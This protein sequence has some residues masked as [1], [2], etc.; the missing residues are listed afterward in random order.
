MPGHRATSMTLEASP[1]SP[2]GIPGVV[3]EAPTVS[4]PGQLA[5]VVNA[6]PQQICHFYLSPRRSMT[7]AARD[8]GSVATPQQGASG[9][10]RSWRS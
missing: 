10:G 4:S 7:S 6:E 1:T 3:L 5:G 9:I 8:S 2:T